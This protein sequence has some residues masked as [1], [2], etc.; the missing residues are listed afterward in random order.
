MIRIELVY[1]AV[2]TEFLNIIQVAGMSLQMPG[3]YPRSIHVS[4]VVERV[5]LGQFVGQILWFSPVIFIPQMLH[6]HLHADLTRR[7]NGHSIRT[8]QKAMLS[9]ILGRIR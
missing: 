7:T 9:K 4:F 1:Y 5:A 3:F 8:F 2:T 6:T